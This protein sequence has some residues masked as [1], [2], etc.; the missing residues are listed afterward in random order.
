MRAARQIAAE[1]RVVTEAAEAEAEAEAAAAARQRRLRDAAA[2][3][4]ELAAL[5]GE[6]VRKMMMMMTALRVR[7]RVPAVSL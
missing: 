2:H 1:C 4:N 7:I 5:R 3:A 6:V